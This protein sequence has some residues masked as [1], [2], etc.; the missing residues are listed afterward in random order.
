MDPDGS[1]SQSAR[2]SSVAEDRARLVNDWLT[3]RAREVVQASLMVPVRGLLGGYIQPGWPPGDSG[4]A[5]TAQAALDEIGL[6]HGC[7]GLYVVDPDGN[8]VAHSINSSPLML[9]IRNATRGVASSRKAQLQVFDE[10]ADNHS[11]A[12]I[13][14][15]WS[16]PERR[17]DTTPKRLL[18]TVPT[19]QRPHFLWRHVWLSR[20]WHSGHGTTRAESIRGR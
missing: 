6:P 20:R 3:E 7:L 11:I 19:F 17:G 2:E 4:V 13:A 10:I 16:L 8:E 1:E 18:G 12:F 9:K 5:Q 14:P 15:V